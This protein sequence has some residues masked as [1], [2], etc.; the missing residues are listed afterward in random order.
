MKTPLVYVWGCSHRRAAVASLPHQGVCIFIYLQSYSCSMWPGERTCVC[1]CECVW[2]PGTSCSLGMEQCFQGSCSPRSGRNT[3]LSPAFSN[4]IYPAANQLRRIRA[5]G[6]RSPYT[7]ACARTRTTEMSPQEM[8][9]R[10]QTRCQAKFEEALS[11]HYRVVLVQSPCFHRALNTWSTTRYLKKLNLHLTAGWFYPS[12]KTNC[13]CKYT[14]SWRSQAERLVLPYCVIH[15]PFGTMWEERKR[16][17]GRKK[18]VFILTWGILIKRQSVYNS[19]SF[20]NITHIHSNQLF[21]P[22]KVSAEFIIFS[23]LNWYS[24][25]RSLDT[26]NCWGSKFKGKQAS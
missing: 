4:R 3:L 6:S 16:G 2:D 14:S 11:A 8:V 17:W 20:T 24:F 12:E 7:P 10:C 23:H 21:W 1:V 25:F 15:Q 9:L 18:K 5:G 13:M 19:I 26:T 22:A